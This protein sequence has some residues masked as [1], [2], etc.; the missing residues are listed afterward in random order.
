MGGEWTDIDPEVQWIQYDIV[1]SGSDFVTLQYPDTD[2][3]EA[4][5]KTWR[6][7]GELIYVEERTWD[8]KEYYRQSD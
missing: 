7:D 4:E 2:Y 6:I 3:T 1:D 8:F 5:Q